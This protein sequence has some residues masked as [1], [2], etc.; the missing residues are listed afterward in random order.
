MQRVNHGK[1]DGVLKPDV[2]RAQMR[3]FSALQALYWIFIGTFFS[4]LVSLLNARGVGGEMIGILTSLMTVGG[5]IGQFVVSYMCDRMETCKRIFIAV[6]VVLYLFC[7]ALYLTEN[8]LLIGIIMFVLGFTKQPLGAVLD[9]WFIKGVSDD[10]RAYGRTRSLGSL[11]YSITVLFYG[12]ALTR[13]GYGIM[14]FVSAGCLLVL[15]YLSLKTPD[16]K[17][18]AAFERVSYKL[19]AISHALTPTL[20]LIFIASMVMGGANNACYNMIPLFLTSLGGTTTALGITYFFNSGMEVPAMRMRWDRL[21]LSPAARLFYSSVLYIVSTFL[22]A[23]STSVWQLVAL[24]GLNGFAF[25][26]SL[27]ARRA[28]VSELSAGPYQATMHGIGD[29]LYS[30]AGP[31]VTNALCGSMLEYSGMRTMLL[32]CVALQAV[33]TAIFFVIYLQAKKRGRADASA[34]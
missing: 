17:K 27:H 2:F 26:V 7:C 10:M 28:V 14:P 13:F 9:T 24:L 34:A 11:G 21:H 8:L 32:F 33:G 16:I 31:I 25:G 5:C 30:G 15:I 12:F 20:L 1:G 22:M 29:M 23:F 19:S 4:F 3:R 18:D 6:L